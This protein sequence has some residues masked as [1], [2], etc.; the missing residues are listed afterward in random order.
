M[1]TVDS[2]IAYPCLL[3]RAKGSGFCPV[4]KKEH[5]DSGARERLIKLMEEANK[6]RKK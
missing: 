6:N 3:E 2:C 1:R 4:H 5:V